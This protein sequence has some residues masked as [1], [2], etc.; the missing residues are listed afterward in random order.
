M[1]EENP[2]HRI[3]GGDIHSQ[4]FFSDGL[5]CPEE[6]YTFA[7]DEAFVDFFLFLTTVNGLQI[8]NGNISAVQQMTSI[9]MEC[10]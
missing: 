9:Q 10:L 2:H 4:T 5:R 8:D 3:F 6:L 7:R 1:V